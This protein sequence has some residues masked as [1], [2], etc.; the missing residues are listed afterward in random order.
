MNHVKSIETKRLFIDG[1]WFATEKTYPLYSPYDGKLIAHI[2]KASPEDVKKAITGAE[3]AFKAFRECSAHER[4]TILQNVAQIIKERKEELAKILALEAAKPIQA[5]RGE[6]NRTIATYQFAAEEAKRLYGETIPMDAALGG[7]NRIG[8]TFREPL[9]VVAAITPFNFPFNLIAHKL[10]PAVAAGNTVVLKPANQTPLSALKIAEIFHEAG[11]PNGALQVITGSG[12][13]IGDILVTD[14]RVK[15]ITFT[16]SS[17]VGKGIKAK[18][19]LKKVTL[20]LGS[21]AALIVEPNV[22]LEKVVKRAVEGA[23]AFAG[24]VCI[25]IQRIY[26]HKEM[27]ESFVEAFTKETEKINVGDPFH[28]N[29]F[30]SAMINEKEAM[31]IENW[32]NEAVKNGAKIQIGGER[33]GSIYSPTVLLN[34]TNEMN[35]S[36]QE[37][38]APVVLIAPYETL[39]EAIDL[40]NDSKYGLNIGIYTENINDALYAA[41]KIESGTVIIND[42]PTF[43]V[44]H[45]PYGGV[46]ESG[47]GR[48]GIKYAIEEMT[49]LKLITI[50]TDF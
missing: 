33:N 23:F 31:R 11:L 35:V 43:R 10:G 27:Y 1:K 12:S 3:K 13:E 37:V 40:V 15:K 49:E 34:T 36:C 42:I 44:D 41:R 38:F 9:G 30:V 17:E 22:P 19:G 21:N 25:S 48:E 20:E 4:A 29:T 18:A 50:K 2:S 14:E 8:F 24:Q 7:E 39:D 46:K 47:Y 45:M 28:E 5:A 26:V 16:G 6:L 32:V